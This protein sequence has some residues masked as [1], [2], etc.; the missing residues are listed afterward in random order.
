MFLHLILVLIVLG[1]LLY[2]VQMIPMDAVILTLIR[3][4]IIVGAVFY[5]IRALG[6]LNG[7]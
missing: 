7:F 1:V 3:V 2:L 4:V 6:L 5:V